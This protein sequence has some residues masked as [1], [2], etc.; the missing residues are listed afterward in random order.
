MPHAQALLLAGPAQRSAAHP[1]QAHL[2]HTVQLEA[3]ANAHA[4]QHRVPLPGKAAAIG[5]CRP[6]VAVWR[7]AAAADGRRWQA[8]FCPQ[9]CHTKLKA[10]VKQQLLHRRHCCR[11]VLAAAAGR[12]RRTA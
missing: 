3:A 12:R 9:L 8:G 11:R 2:G 1:S 4:L 7:T 10:L 5:R 6:V